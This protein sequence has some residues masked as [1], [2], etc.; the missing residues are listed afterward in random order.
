VNR[1]LLVPEVVQT[2]AMDCGPAALK[3]LLEGFGVN[4]SY[5]RLREACQTD[6][7]GTSID[8]LED[9]LLQLGM[10]AEQTIVPADQLLAMDL[11]PAL[12]VLRLPSGF[13]HFVVAWRAS[14][15]VV[16]VMD[17]AAGRR[18][19]PREKFLRELY[20]HEMNLQ[21]SVFLEIAASNGWAAALDRRLA[22]LGARSER[23]VAFETLASGDWRCLACVD[24]ATRVI[25]S[26]VRTRGLARGNEAAA[27]LAELR[28]QALAV[29]DAIPAPYWSARPAPSDSDSGEEPQVRLRGAVVL[30]V[31]RATAAAH[32][33]DE[34]RAPLP[35]DLVA[36]LEEP[37]SRPL[38]HV[39][40][41]AFEG[42]R[43][44][45]LA[46]WLAA[47]VVA[48]TL[49]RVLEVV[50]LRAVLDLGRELGLVQQRLGGLGALVLFAVLLLALETSLLGGTMRLGRR[51]EA[52]LR[53]AFAR[54]I[55][56][57]GDRYFS[58]R[59]VSD[60]A[61]RS[62]AVHAVRSLPE[63]VS[64]IARTALEAV[65]TASAIAWFDPSAAVLAL[66]A[67]SVAVGLP[68]AGLPVWTERDM[69]LR[70]HRGAV[71]RFHLDVLLAAAPVRAHRAERGVAREHESL[72]VAWARAGRELVQAHVVLET[73]QTCVGVALAAWVL[74]RHVTAAAHVSSVI[75][76]AY[77]ALNLP[78]LGQELAAL[79]RQIP[80]RR[81]TM[82]RL[83]ELFGAGE[84]GCAP[85]PAAGPE[86]DEPTQAPQPPHGTPAPPI[87]L[88]FE[89]VDVVAGGHPILQGVDLRIERATHVAILGASGAGKSSLLGLLLGWHRA[90][91]GRVLVDGRPLDVAALQELRAA[92][93]WVDPATHLWN[94]SLL[95]NVLYGAPPG[96]ARSLRSALETS[97][98]GEVL[99]GLPRGL[100]TRLGEGG[101]LVSGGEGQRVRIA[102][103]MLRARPRLV[104]LDEPFRG[105]D[106]DRRHALLGRVRDAW[107]DVTLLCVTHDVAEAA[108]FD[109]VLVV[110]DGRV[111]EDGTPAELA[112]RETSRYRA[113][114]DEEATAQRQVWADP[115]WRRVRVD[116][117]RI[118]E[119]VASLSEA[120]A[121]SLGDERGCA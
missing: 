97:D 117:G 63:L 115:R 23:R 86:L 78:V 55:P 60:M 42:A 89:Q 12:V 36:A 90:A 18:W 21:S 102:R 101:A 48:V 59:P 76:V 120:R 96:A 57:L 5:G 119:G 103:A 28:A 69:R 85:H 118:V 40:S 26:V 49:A 98:L 25:E 107:K 20:V 6:V 47:A 116:Q 16:Q 92:C 79:L 31:R 82:V 30:R 15:G 77:W 64:Q 10:E 100:D 88:A 70:S 8:A 51:V 74:V 72:L 29:E 32:T 53:L 17:P 58:T 75:L 87:A 56:R 113:L 104:L 22:R 41:L 108:A 110:H 27:A 39:A 94:R 46:G 33:V 71:A 91:Q 2:S 13:T 43:G 66:A 37:P 38:K 73:L 65:V 67:G 99:D 4:A 105:L 11:L 7:D 68:L 114:I 1:A 9:V 81:N 50:L 45:A 61:E 111:V 35:P 83:L 80:E 112:A 106:R 62:H 44:A 24:A 54:K 95:D 121:A 84:E 34:T 3:A 52:R 19:L 14:A 93:V 109:R